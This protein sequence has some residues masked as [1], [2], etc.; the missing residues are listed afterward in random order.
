[1]NWFS[2]IVLYVVI[3]WLV[4][5]VV[6]PWGVRV[7][8][9]IEPGMATSAPERP[10]L[11]RKVA[12]TSGLAALMWVATYFIIISDLVTLRPPPGSP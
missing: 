7:P 8:D 1:M 9:K 11:W 12:V 2:G 5:F 4:L 3:W 10:L 6:L